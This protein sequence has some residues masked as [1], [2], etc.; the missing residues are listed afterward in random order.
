MIGESERL[1]WLA[2]CRARVRE[3]TSVHEL[4]SRLQKAGLTICDS[5]LI[6]RDSLEVELGQAKEIVTKHR[7]WRDVVAASSALHEELEAHIRSGERSKGGP[8]DDRRT[9]EV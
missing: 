8:D 5:I 1:H 6:L 9:P 4:V 2:D 7:A 3:G